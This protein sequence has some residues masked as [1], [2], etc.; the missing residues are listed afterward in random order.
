MQKPLFLLIA[1]LYMCAPLQA[2]IDGDNIFQNDQVIT[3]ELEFSQVGFYDS[4]VLNYETATYMKADLT[5]TDE[6]GTAIFEDVGVRFKGNSTFNHPGNKKAFKIDFNEYISGQNYDGLKK[7][8]F[9]NGFKDPSLMREKIFFDM[10]QDAGVPAPRANFANVYFNGT[11][12]GFYTVVEQ[13]DDQFLDWRILDDDGNLFKAGDNFGGGPGGGGDAADLVYYGAD[14]ATYADKYELKTNETENDWSDLIE[15]IDFI[16]N[17]SATAF[18]N[19]LGNHIELQEYLRSV[20]LDNLF[21]N[22]DSYTGSA[23]NYYIYHNLTTNKWEWIKWDGNESFGSYGGGGGPGG[24]VNMI[25]LPLDYHDNDRPL[26]ENVFAS[27]TLYGQYEEE[28]CYLKNNFFNAASMNPRIDA[29]KTLIQSSVYADNNKQYTNANF[30][31][32]IEGNITTGG[33]PGGGGVVY[34]IKSFIQEK[35]SFVSG[36]L[37]CASVATNDPIETSITTYPNP[38]DNSVLIDLET[39]QFQ[40]VTIFDCLGKEVYVQEINGQATVE[41]NL[42]FL[43]KG[44]YFG[45]LNLE[46]GKTDGNTMFKLVKE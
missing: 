44:I 9:S 25:T 17:S 24:G 39:A 31:D 22:L 15:F 30:D 3:I 34:G 45:Q 46:N 42:S 27:P 16:N 23:R 7:L 36:L 40:S 13:I 19:E 14:Q 26:L 37:N 5:L 6:T 11:L 12:W 32:V 21:S 38:F 4:L 43:E 28:I 33:G 1:L 18:E 29:I 2:Q 10:C 8:N 41:L 35:N 20:A